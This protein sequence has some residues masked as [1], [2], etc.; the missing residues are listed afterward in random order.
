MT[1]SDNFSQ[2]FSLEIAHDCTQKFLYCSPIISSQIFYSDCT[3][4]NHQITNRDLQLAIVLSSQSWSFNLEFSPSLF[5]SVN[6]VLHH[7]LI[8][9]SHY[10]LK[11]FKRQLF[12]LVSSGL[13]W[14]S[15]SLNLVGDSNSGHFRMLIFSQFSRFSDIYFVNLLSH[16]IKRLYLSP[17]LLFSFF[18]RRTSPHVNEVI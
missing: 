5:R 11:S 18:L 13:S 2:K 10:S 15:V 3:L 16:C 6:L 1:F 4:G 17:K 9:L 8:L 7:C 14:G 12:K